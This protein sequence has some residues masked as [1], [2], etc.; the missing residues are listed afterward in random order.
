MSW[1]VRA[2]GDTCTGST[3]TPGTQNTSKELNVLITRKEARRNYC[4]K[5]SDSDS[6]SLSMVLLPSVINS[7][8]G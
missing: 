3:H 2:D 6:S 7:R 1:G 4:A 5:S 8:P